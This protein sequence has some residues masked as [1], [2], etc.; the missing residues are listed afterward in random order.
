[1]RRT[2]TR[3]AAPARND[4]QPVRVSLLGLGLQILD[5]CALGIQE[6]EPEQL[7][8]HGL[9]GACASGA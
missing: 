7:W 8:I 1:V 5:G 3:A 2:L 9:A 6:Q 4:Q